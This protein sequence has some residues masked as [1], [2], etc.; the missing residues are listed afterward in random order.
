MQRKGRNMLG[1]DS[2]WWTMLYKERSRALQ[3]TATTQEQRGKSDV[4]GREGEWAK[5]RGRR[6]EEGEAV[7][8][9]L[10]RRGDLREAQRKTETREGTLARRGAYARH[11]GRREGDARR[12][13]QRRGERN[14]AARPR[15]I[16]KY[17][18][19]ASILRT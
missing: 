12:G 11:R 10:A 6:G 1:W 17:N 3:H 13:R 14:A 5:E 2:G 15:A 18:T 16:P 19:L 9:T 4:R 7:A 8:K